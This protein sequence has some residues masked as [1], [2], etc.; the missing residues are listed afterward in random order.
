MFINSIDKTEVRNA[1]MQDP[2]RYYIWF[3]SKYVNY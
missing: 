3:I 2:I 1:N